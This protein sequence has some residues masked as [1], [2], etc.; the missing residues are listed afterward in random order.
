MLT[1][2]LTRSRLLGLGLLLLLASCLQSPV[3]QAQESIPQTAWAYSFKPA[4]Q[5][6]ITDTTAP[7]GA[8]FLIRHTDA[9]PFA[10]IWVWVETKAPGDSTF[11]RVRVEV[12]LAERTG[13]WLGRGAGAI[14]EHRAPPTPNGPL[15]FTKAGRYTVR[16]EQAMRTNPLP[17]I[18]Q[19]GLRI[20]KK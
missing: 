11:Q 17:E 6:D 16:F 10:N 9:Y 19:V 20:E 12:P 3:Y 2:I 5:F 14:W 4:F 13:R 8:Y 1:K 7:Y 18:L 15:R